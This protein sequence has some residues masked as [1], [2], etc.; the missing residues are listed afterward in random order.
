MKKLLMSLGLVVLFGPMISIAWAQQGAG[1]GMKN[2]YSRQYDT[3]AVE[4][5]EGDVVEVTNNP[6][7]KNAAMEGVHMLVKTG[8]GNIPVH[9]G[10]VWY[11]NQQEAFHKGDHVV[12]TGSRI[13]F[14]GKFVIVAATVQRNKMVLHL[15]DRN[16]FPAWRGWRMGQRVNR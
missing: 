7:R 14:S 2:Q 8:S 12:I 16:G 5:I 3:N 9:L 13:S 6:S 1:K 4:T 11:M 15:R 10:P